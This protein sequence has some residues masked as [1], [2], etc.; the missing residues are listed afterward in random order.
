MDLEK[1]VGERLKKEDFGFFYIIL[2]KEFRF[3]WFLVYNQSP[4]IFGEIKTEKNNEESPPEERIVYGIY[5]S[6]EQLNDKDKVFKLDILENSRV[7]VKAFILYEAIENYARIG[8]L[9]F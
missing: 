9:P 3:D 4:K 8:D 5:R 7:S 1:S 6:A 2:K